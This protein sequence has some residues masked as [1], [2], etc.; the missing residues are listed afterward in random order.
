MKKSKT[1]KIIMIISFLLM[2]LILGFLMWRM[3]FQEKAILPIK[4]E[5]PSD[6]ITDGLPL[7][8]D[9]TPI[10]SDETGEGSIKPGGDVPVAP[11]DSQE[12]ETEEIN[13]IALGGITRTSTVVESRS[14]NPVLSKDG[15]AVQFYNKDDN[16]FYIVNDKGDLIPLSDKSF[17]NVSDVEW[18]PNRTKAVIEYPDKTKIIYDFVSNKQITLPKH[19]EDFSFSS[20]SEKLIN[21]SLGIDPDNRWLIISNSNGSQTRAIENIGE[22]DRWIIPSWS[23]NNQSV[24]MYTKGVDANRRR[25]YF[26]GEH[27]QNFKSTTIEG[28]GFQPQWSQNGDKLLYSAYSPKDDFNPRLWIVNASGDDIGRNRKSLQ[29]ETWAEKCTFANN[30]EVYCAVPKNLEPMSGMF[31][32]LALRTSD[33]LYKINIDTGQKTLIAIP[34]EAYNISSIIVNKDQ[35]NL[36]FTDHTSEKIHK[37]N[38]QK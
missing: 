24:G 6:P 26:I 13:E 35:S 9:G 33:D 32:E 15:G 4:Q 17:Y 8:P 27:D 29:L 18:A 1:K 11:Q 34:D 3:F 20:N 14:L 10:I 21:K 31:P 38:L 36:F 23:P 37:I 7:S 28:W 19:W 2:V 22:N 16:K 25:V 5:K 12:S 30:S